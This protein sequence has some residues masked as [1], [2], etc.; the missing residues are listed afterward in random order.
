MVAVLCV[1]DVRSAM[2][3]LYLQTN[4]YNHVRILAGGI[5]GL[6]EQLK[7][8]AVRKHVMNSSAGKNQ[9]A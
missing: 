1:S 3:Y 5:V 8:G 7:P 4:G 6:A 2:A 9:R